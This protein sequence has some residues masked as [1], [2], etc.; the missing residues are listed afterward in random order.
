MQIYVYQ[1]KYAHDYSWS[2]HVNWGRGDAQ[3]G[4]PSNN[5]KLTELSTALIDKKQLQNYLHRLYQQ[6]KQTALYIAEILA[7]R[8][9]VT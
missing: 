1:Y 7:V 4:L 5:R 3:G 9:R 8:A 2:C 6:Q